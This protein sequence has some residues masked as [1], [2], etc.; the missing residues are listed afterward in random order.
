VHPN[1]R[2]GEHGVVVNP[3]SSAI[4][5]LDG[6]DVVLTRQAR[7]A[8]DRV[9]LEVVK[10]GAAPG[11]SARAGAERELREEVGLVAARWDDLGSVYEIPSIV[12]EPVQLFLARDL[13]SVATELEDV[14]SIAAVRMP[15][16]DAVLAAARGEIADAVTAAALLRAAQRLQ[17][18]AAR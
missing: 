15:F 3:P 16:R 18:E 2:P 17:D 6:D 7:Y 9:V 10:G 5:A 13:R 11:E 4:V 1:G 14:E 8:I 12:Q